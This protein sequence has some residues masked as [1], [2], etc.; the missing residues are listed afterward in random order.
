MRHTGF[1]GTVR[2]F[3]RR[4][5]F[6]AI[7]LALLHSPTAWSSPPHV[8]TMARF[9][10][11]LSPPSVRKSL[12][13]PRPSVRV[14]CVLRK[15]DQS[16]N[17]HTEI[18]PPGATSVVVEVPSGPFGGTSPDNYLCIA[19]VTLGVGPYDNQV[20]S[21][22]FAYAGDPSSGMFVLTPITTATIS[23]T[24]PRLKN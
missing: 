11:R 14:T 1:S 3:Y 4:I 17:Q 23:F 7:T 22:P 21:G 20:V 10:V 24:P 5:G 18:A 15:G 9:T 16:L 2:S 8:N 6:F 19:A 13:R 12:A